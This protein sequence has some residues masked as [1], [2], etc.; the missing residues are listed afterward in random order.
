VRS[1]IEA[2]YWPH[3]MAARAFL[4]RHLLVRSGAFLLAWKRLLV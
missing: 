2:R 3:P 1:A 4:D